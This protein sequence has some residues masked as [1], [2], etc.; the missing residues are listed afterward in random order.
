MLKIPGSFEPE[1][2]DAHDERR[3]SQVC[4]ITLSE[5]DL[6]PGDGSE[7]IQGCMAEKEEKEFSFGSSLP[8]YSPGCPGNCSPSSR[9][10]P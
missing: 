7:K 10:C 8:T 3:L 4:L 6:I 2:K 9:N 1:G 5:I